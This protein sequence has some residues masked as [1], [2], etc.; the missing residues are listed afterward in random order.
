MFSVASINSTTIQSII[1]YDTCILRR[2][3]DFFAHWLELWITDFWVMGSNSIRDVGC[4][5]TMHHFLV[6]NCIVFG[7]PTFIVRTSHMIYFLLHFRRNSSMQN[8]R[9]LLTQMSIISSNCLC[10]TKKTTGYCWLKKHNE[11][12]LKP[13]NIG[14]R[15]QTNIL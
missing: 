3:V 13:G 2:G 10:P 12:Q 8:Q 6:M 5:Q 15:E 14:L 9:P 4:F 7:E 11:N 1:I